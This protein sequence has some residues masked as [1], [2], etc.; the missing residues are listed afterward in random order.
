MDAAALQSATIAAINAARDG[1]GNQLVVA[2]AGSA[3][4]FVV[5]RSSSADTS[6]SSSVSIT[7]GSDTTNVFAFSAAEAMAAA[8]TAAKSAKSSAETAISALEI[9]YDFASGDKGLA[10]IESVGAKAAGI[11]CY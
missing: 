10:A 4:E 1:D 3:D 7:G 6:F 9:L 8:D 5:L 2:S 11:G